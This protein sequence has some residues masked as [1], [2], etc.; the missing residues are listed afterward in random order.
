LDKSYEVYAFRIEPAEAYRVGVLFT[1]ITDRKRQEEKLE[2]MVAERTAALRE[3]VG[4]LEAF[5]Y[6]IAHDM[7]APL[8]GMRSFADL[9]T[10]EHASQLDPKALDYLRRIGTS[11]H[12]MDALIQDVLNYSKI[13]KAEVIIEPQDLDRLTREIVESY[14]QWQSSKAEIKIRGILPRV[15]GNQAFLTQCISNLL[16]NAV[17][18]VAPGVVPRVCIWVEEVPTPSISH[19]G[20]N[21]GAISLEHP[22]RRPPVS[23][24]RLFFEDNGIG[25]APDKHARIFRMFERI[26]PAAEYE[27]T[28]IGLTIACRAAE[29]MGGSIGFESKLGHGSRF[30]I[31]LKKS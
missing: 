9:L 12:R 31:Q 5:S 7:R 20:R 2:K 23:L 21:D 18:F 25:I 4:E 17:K 6:S 1:D 24:V 29:R 8:R 3:T 10:A 14:P 16:S 15:L 13:I 27:G 28:G 30:W 11:A 19:A 26:H 22:T